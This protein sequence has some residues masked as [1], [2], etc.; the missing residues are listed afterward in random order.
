MKPRQADPCNCVG[1][2]PLP[3]SPSN[4]GPREQPA[5]VTMK[6]LVS[7]SIHPVWTSIRAVR[8]AVG[9][10]LGQ[11]PPSFVNAAMMV[12]SE[13]LENA[14]K[15][16]EEVPAAP[17][18]LFSLDLVDSRARIEAV[19]GATDPAVVARLM[20]H[21]RLLNQAEDKAALYLARLQELLACP[22]NSARLGIYRIAYEGEF[23][24][25]CTY[26]NEV[27]TVTATR[28]VPWCNG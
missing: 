18:I 22:T 16:G 24:L 10:A 27:V 21:I 14:I 28:S 1:V 17:V 11:Y 4:E 26:E 7:T 5:P 3:T 20:E 12:S 25:Q 8:S 19:N 2:G 9:E 23:D 6:P 13:L 15:Y